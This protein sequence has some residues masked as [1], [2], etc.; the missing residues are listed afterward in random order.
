MV[1]VPL[2][3]AAADA[4]PPV[5]A[6]VAVAEGVAAVD[7]VAVVAAKAGTAK[8]PQLA[9]I[10]NANRRGEEILAAGKARRALYIVFLPG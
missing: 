9:L 3:V 6:G 2:P 5:V 8:E 10:T 7:V 1:S 4:A